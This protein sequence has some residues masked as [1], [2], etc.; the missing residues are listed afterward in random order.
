VQSLRHAGTVEEARRAVASRLTALSQAQDLLTRSHHAGADIWAVVEGTLKPHTPGPDRIS[1]EGPD[2]R[3]DPQQ[4]LGLSLALHELGTNAAKHG[5][6]SAEGGRVAI[7]WTH[8]PG[9][10]FTF[11]WTESGGPRVR[12]P[13]T[14]GFGST[15][16]D[17][18]AGSYF[19]GA[20]EVAFPAQGV[21]FAID[22]VIAER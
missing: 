1:I 21:T 10:A 17:R 18:V 11:R 20:S 6:L 15:I 2:L 14:R 19:D 4:V 8:D 12:P 3:L 9:G 7:R 5:A 13:G 22:G 16:L